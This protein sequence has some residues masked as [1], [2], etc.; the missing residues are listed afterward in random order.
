MNDENKKRKRP[1][2]TTKSK[3]K[4]RTTKTKKRKSKPKKKKEKLPP[5]SKEQQSLV[6][7]FEIIDRMWCFLSKRKALTSANV[8]MNLARSATGKVLTIERLRVVCDVAPDVLMLAKESTESCI[9]A[10]VSDDATTEMIQMTTLKGAG[11]GHSNKRKKLFEACVRKQGANNESETKDKLLLLEEASLQKPETIKD[12]IQTEN[13]DTTSPIIV[14]PTKP[15][16]IVKYLRS[17]EF[18]ENQIAHQHV[19]PRRPGKFVTSLRPE[20]PESVLNALENGI[21]ITKF[22]SHQDDAIRAIRNGS[23]LVLSSYTG[24]G[25]SVAFNLPVLETVLNHPDHACTAL[26]LFPTKALAQDQL[27]ALKKI[28][29]ALPREVMDEILMVETLDGDTSWSERDVIRKWN[30]SSVLLSNPDLIHYTILPNHTHWRH[31]L[32]TLKYIVLDEAHVY[33]GVFGSN[34]SLVLRRLLRVSR[35][36]GASP[37]VLSF[38]ATIE[39]PEEHFEMLFPRDIWCRKLAVISECLGAP[40][41]SKTFLLWNP[42]LVCGEEM[43]ESEAKKVAKKKKKVEKEKVEKKI[44]KSENNRTISA[45]SFVPKG[46]QLPIHSAMPADETPRRRSSIFET[47]KILAALVKIECRTLCFSTTRKLTELVLRYTK[48][49]LK[50]THPHLID[51]VM[52]YR[53]G[54]TR[55]ERHALENKLKKGEIL[56]LTSTNALELGVDLCNLHATVELG[57]SS[58]S[59]MMQRAGRSGRNG[60]DSLSIVVCFDSP[61]DQFYAHRG[62]RLFQRKGT[63]VVRSVRA[64]SAR[65]LIISLTSNG[66]FVVTSTRTHIIQSTYLYR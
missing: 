51:K 58:Y 41:G 20:P 49:I 50:E 13:E 11:K 29:N 5:L 59:S 32:S 14:D 54:Y 4:T 45:N 12:T 10:K 43:K 2:K 55:S 18:Y 27:A 36:L 62:A 44:E 64:R 31:Q 52:S 7:D 9:F 30:A 34:V 3:K 56:A 17:R 47:A 1:I 48:D 28:V 40:Q 60:K 8:I 61:T 21:G 26:Y 46:N 16:Q 66:T 23:H 42:P 65:M 15:S 25:K 19:N 35:S 24:S 57:I 22:Y 6:D 39:N 53:A 37:Q 63:P 33:R 38:S